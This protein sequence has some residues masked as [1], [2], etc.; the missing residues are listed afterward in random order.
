MTAGQPAFAGGWVIQRETGSAQDLHERSASS[1][2][3][4]TARVV[5]ILEADSPALVLGSGQQKASVDTGLAARMGIA[6]AR[7]RSGGGAVLVGPDLAIWVDL[8]VPTGDPL[9]DDDVG[10]AAWWVGEAWSQAAREAG[11]EPVEVWKG[12]MVRHPW[13]DRICFAGVGPGEVLCGPHKLVGISQR[14]TRDGAL[15]QT[16]VLCQWDPQ[17]LVS[18][19][20]TEGPV[21]E[22]SSL[23]PAA[24]TV[25]PDEGL[26]LRHALV[27]VLTAP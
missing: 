5:R 6:V 7:R 22:V 16:A 10:R 4:P 14:R 19:L 2:A 8:V 18:L 23:G 3:P 26:G 1:L 25:T 17:L 24:R 21:P 15:F 13:S 9:W 11:I 20:S 27:S 12:P